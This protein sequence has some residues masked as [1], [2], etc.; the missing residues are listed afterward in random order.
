MSGLWPWM[1]VGVIS[2]V[3]AVGTAISAIFDAKREDDEKAQL[4]EWAKW[5]GWR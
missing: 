2:L 5:K 1:V 3:G 4:E